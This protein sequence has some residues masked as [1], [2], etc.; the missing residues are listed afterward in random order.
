MPLSSTVVVW[1]VFA[2]GD[3]STVFHRQL[4]KLAA[5]AGKLRRIEV[6]VKGAAPD[7]VAVSDVIQRVVRDTDV[8]FTY[9]ERREEDPSEYDAIKFIHELSQDTGESILYFHL[10]GVSYARKDPVKYLCSL[11]WGDWL[12]W[13]FLERFDY[14]AGILSSGFDVVGVNFQ[15][16]TYKGELRNAFEG[17]F[18]LSTA[19]HVRSLP[20]PLTPEVL[21]S[22]YGSDAKN[23]WRLYYEW[24]IT[25]ASSHKNY[26]NAYKSHS[27]LEPD[28][29]YKTRFSRHMFAAT[30][31]PSPELY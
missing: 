24:Y 28:F 29:H 10:K 18:W 15:Q 19:S 20:V 5:I 9:F 2:V 4:A 30:L 27:V 16:Y 22:R 26:F 8:C 7:A 21:M 17:N 1:Y 6:L 31:R 12:E 23:S 3:Y 25:S 11:D 13:C 14:C